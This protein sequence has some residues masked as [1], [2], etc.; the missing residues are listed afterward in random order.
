M[1][2]KRQIDPLFWIDGDLS[3]ISDKAKLL[4]I[5]LWNF[6]DDNGVIPNNPYEIKGAIFP[7]SQVKIDKNID[8]L[9]K[10]NKLIP[11]EVEGK[12]YLWIKNFIKHQKIDYPAYKYPLS[13]S[14][15]GELARIRRGLAKSRESRV[16]LNRESKGLLNKFFPI[17]GRD[18]EV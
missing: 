6:A 14:V 3:K 5:G 15:R 12:Q 16:E 17:R 4:Y 9:I 2:R 1:A 10:I 13:E 8:E 18:K 7:H 11:Y